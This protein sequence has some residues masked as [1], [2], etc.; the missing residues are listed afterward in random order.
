MYLSFPLSLLPRGH[1]PTHLTV[2]RE[3]ERLQCFCQPTSLIAFASKPGHISRKSRQSRKKLKTCM[4]CKQHSHWIAGSLCLSHPWA[5]SLS[6]NCMMQPKLAYLEENHMTRS[7]QQHSHSNFKIPH[8][9]ITKH[10]FTVRRC[11]D[12]T[13]LCLTGTC[14]TLSSV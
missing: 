13:M 2:E 6:Y 9:T 8:V 5:T 10:T 3:R 11:W 12:L 1:W 4:T 14:R 7:M